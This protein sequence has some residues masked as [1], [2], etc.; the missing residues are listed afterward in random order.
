M[1]KTHNWQDK[2]VAPMQD[3]PETP[4]PPYNLEDSD[5]YSTSTLHNPEVTELEAGIPYQVRGSISPP[6]RCFSPMDGN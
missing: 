6:V 4:P 3:R 1:N 5:P 2:A